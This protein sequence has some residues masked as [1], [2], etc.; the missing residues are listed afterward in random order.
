VGHFNLAPIYINTLNGNTAF[1]TVSNGTGALLYDGYI[2]VSGNVEGSTTKGILFDIATTGDTFQRSK[3]VA[4]VECNNTANCTR[5]HVVAG[6]VATPY[7]DFLET[8][9]W[10]DNPVGQNINGFD[11]ENLSGTA[12]Q[13]TS[14]DSTA[15]A[16]ISFGQPGIENW[17]LDSTL[18]SNVQ[19]NFQLVDQVH[20]S[21][22]FIVQPSALGLT[23]RTDGTQINGT[24]L[25]PENAG[26]AGAGGW[27]IFW[28]DSTAHTFK[29]INNNGTAY[30]VM[31][32][33][34]TTGAQW[35]TGGGGALPTASATTTFFPAMGQSATSTTDTFMQVIGVAC[36]AKNLQCNVTAAQGGGKSDTFTLRSAGATTALTC[37]ATNT[38]S[39]TDTTHTVSL[40]AG[41]L[42]DFQDVPSSTASA[43]NGGCAW[44]C[45]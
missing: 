20:S 24:I 17:L 7:M 23:I 12:F 36:T 14:P 40:A 26:R 25:E 18:A 45:Q 44:Q 8:T 37:Q 10:S 38:T 3:V 28:E 21:I 39:C 19:S 16:L 31:G 33:Q 29:M 13:V 6:A 30:A 41:A 43:R 5:L 1:K 32:N 4:A 9:G 11:N 15:S 35:F 22:P 2:M 27:G 42:V 34:S